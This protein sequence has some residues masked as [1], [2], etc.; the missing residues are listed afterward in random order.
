MRTLQVVKVVQRVSLLFPCNVR[1]GWKANLRLCF[2]PWKNYIYSWQGPILFSPLLTYHT[3]Q[4]SLALLLNHFFM[5]LSPK[6]WR[7]N[8]DIQI[9]PPFQKPQLFLREGN[10]KNGQN[11]DL[12]VLNL[13]V[14]GTPYLHILYSYEYYVV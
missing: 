10:M 5:N 4:P 11:T 12:D 3:V 14:I 9:F 8:V 13:A 2:L 7:W 1:T 6:K